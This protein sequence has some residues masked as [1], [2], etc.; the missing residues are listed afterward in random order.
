MKVTTVKE[1]RKHELLMEAR[2]S[3]LSW[4][5]SSTPY[6]HSSTSAS[7]NRADPLDIL[8]EATVLKYVPSATNV[9]NCLLHSK[10]NLP[11]EKIKTKIESRQELIHSKNLIHVLDDHAFIFYYQEIME[12][13]CQPESMDLVQG[14]RR[15]VRC[16]GDIVK[17]QSEE[18]L[19]KIADSIQKYMISLYDMMAAHPSWKGD[20]SAETKMMMETFIYS[21]CHDMILNL[22]RRKQDQSQ[23]EGYSFS[24]R[25]DFLQFV[26]PE[27]LE[28]NYIVSD[29][30][31]T[32]SFWRD[33]LARPI[34]LLQSLDYLQ[35]PSQMLRCIL[36][37]YRAVN[38][39]LKVAG[40]KVNDQGERNDI[41]MPSA[42]D[43]LPTLILAIIYSN[44]RNIPI[45]LDFIELFATPDQVRGEAGYAFTNLL[46][47][48][49][50]IK[51]M[52]LGESSESGNPSLQ[53]SP[54]ELKQRL[55]EFQETLANQKVQGDDG[56]RNEDVRVN[57][58]D[59][60]EEQHR[61]ENKVLKMSNADMRPIHIPVSQLA[62][63]RQR[64]EDLSKWARIY[65][66]T[67]KPP[68]IAQTA[69]GEE[70]GQSREA[71][72]FVPKVASPH[73][74]PDGFKRSYRFLATEPDEIRMSD[75]PA[76]LEEYRMLVRTTELLLAERQSVVSKQHEIAMKTRKEI[77]E[78][79]LL[80][81][82][83]C[84]GKEPDT[85]E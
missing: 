57:A 79:S 71:V 1:E 28:I 48:V 68:E 4:V 37:M 50:F 30:Q 20:D 32:N 52:D 75:I 77:L 69:S 73:P 21:K 8:N 44:A 7:S 46:S 58:Q 36:E 38:H 45:H 64:G 67:T 24:D 13:L 61:T 19:E 18:N 72:Q 6:K 17:Q 22:L 70:T 47:A 54:S 41:K 15:F 59:H 62:A 74:L 76:L 51:Q 80:E 10:E 29:E 33:A 81:A 39:A 42:D 40:E 66:D 26:E 84:V 85:D 63:A 35:A 49:H 53:I 34:A 14:M 82:S 60:D 2:R 65:V 5:K 78:E 25:L 11:V 55:S 16:F 43:L 31:Q 3:R 12:R 9:L 83:K 27:H 56:A 23:S